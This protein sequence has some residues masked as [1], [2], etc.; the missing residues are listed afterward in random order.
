MQEIVSALCKN[1]SIYRIQECG[2]IKRANP[3]TALYHLLS[4]WP[5]EEMWSEWGRSCLLRARRFARATSSESRPRLF[6]HVIHDSFQ[7]AIGF[8]EDFELA[9]GAGAGFE[10]VAHAI[11]GFAAAEFLDHG[12]D[13]REILF[14]QIALRYFLLLAEV[15]EI[16]VQAIT[17][18]AELVLHQQRACVLAEVLR[19]EE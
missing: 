4:G 5:Q 6:R 18:G 1:E 12:I 19:S 16:P 3:V 7:I 14:D 9:V 8:F 10:D 11:D 13:E 17:H 2:R 15:D